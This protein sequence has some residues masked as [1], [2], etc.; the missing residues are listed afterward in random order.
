MD[1]GKV[2]L[3]LEIPYGLSLLAYHD[4]RAEVRGLDLV[5]PSDWP[6]VPTVHLAFQIMVGI[7]TYL[8]LLAVWCLWLMLRRR[9]LAAHRHL[10]GAITLAGP[11]GFLAIEAGWTVT[12]V[13][14]QPWIIHGVL[15]TSQAVTPMPGLTWTFTGFSVLYLFL[16]LVVAWL[17]YAQ[18]IRSPRHQE[19]HRSY[20]PGGT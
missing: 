7:G 17:L 2:R 14:R 18:I 1:H 19:W 16:G 15:R 8:A 10:L 6:H 5:E 3:G 4:P 11:L 9:D 20:F 13:G 12:E